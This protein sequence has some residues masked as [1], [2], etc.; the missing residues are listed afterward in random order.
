MRSNGPRARSRFDASARRFAPTN[1][2]DVDPVSI[3]TGDFP[4]PSVWSATMTDGRLRVTAAVDAAAERAE[5]LADELF[6]LGATAVFERPGPDGAVTL[7]ADLGPEQFERLRNV[8]PRARVLGA[9][10]AW[11]HGWRQHA[12]AWRCGER[13]VLRPTWVDPAPV[14]PGELEVLVEPGG[15]FGSGSHPTTRLCVAAVERLV[16]PGDRVLDVGCGTG[17]LGVVAAMLGATHVDA[18]DIDPEAVRATSEVAR[19]NSVGSRVSAS[20]TPIGQLTD[21][22]DLVVAN[23]LLPVIEDLGRELVERVAPG[24]TLVVSGL[25]VEQIGRTTSALAPLVSVDQLGDGQWVA[26]LCRRRIG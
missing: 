3:A 9:E 22:Y 21:R 5:L 10:P 8:H 7:V 16:R 19:I 23:L 17:V 15:A 6:G 1:Q 25:L 13:I 20:L 26:L 18:V 24:G 11:D 12:R 2:G 4:V 14:E